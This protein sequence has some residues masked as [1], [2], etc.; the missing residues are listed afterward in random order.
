MPI[1]FSWRLVRACRSTTH[2]QTA[3]AG[4]V[5]IVCEC[6]TPGAG[7]NLST[8]DRS[9]LWETCSSPDQSICVQG[10]GSPLDAGGDTKLV[11]LRIC[12]RYPASRPEGP[13]VI[14]E[15]PSAERLQPLDFDLDI[16]GDDVHMHA[17]LPGLRLGYPLEKERGSIYVLGHKDRVS[18]LRSRCVLVCGGCGIRLG[19]RHSQLARLRIPRPSSAPS[20]G[21][22]RW[23][24]VPASTPGVAAWLGS[25]HRRL[26]G[27]LDGCPKLE[28]L[29]LDRAEGVVEVPQIDSRLCLDCLTGRL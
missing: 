7:D 25:A 14:V 4:G 8:I 15:S 11:V 20:G 26:G 9:A 13:D 23:T 10:K 22:A 16:L 24:F 19:P 28:K 12:H 17:V 1:E 6:V 18:H 3:I 29:R 5:G 27:P 2:P 21:S